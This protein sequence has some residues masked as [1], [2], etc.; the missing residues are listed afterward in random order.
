[1]ISF[2]NLLAYLFLALFIS[3]LISEFIFFV[4]DYFIS[5]QRPNGPMATFKKLRRDWELPPRPTHPLN[6]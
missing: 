2:I 5:R 6:P 3:L 4:R 1:M